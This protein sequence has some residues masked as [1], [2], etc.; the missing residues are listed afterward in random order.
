MIQTDP[1]LPQPVAANAL[2][3]SQQEQSDGDWAQLSRWYKA[4]R[5]IITGRSQRPRVVFMGDSITENWARA[6]PDLFAG[7]CKNRGISGQTTAQMLVRF[8]ED[9]LALEPAA[10]HLIAGTNDIAGNGGPVTLHQIYN[11]LAAMAKLARLHGIAVVLGAI[12]P[13]TDFF[14]NPGLRPAGH[15]AALNDWLRN[16]ADEQEVLFVDYFTALSD[17]A[18][19]FRSGLSNDG[20][21]PNANGYEIMRK[22][23]GDA[24]APFLK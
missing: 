19:S 16:F 22:L 10:M 1:E 20:A 3:G 8:P 18:R 5:E 9:V 7:A 6:D 2:Q 11:R 17:E 13:A 14:W 21:H 12:P 4:N 15:I 24:I 23:A